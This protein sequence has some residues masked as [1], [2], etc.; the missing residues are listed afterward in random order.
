MGKKRKAKRV[1]VMIDLHIVVAS[2]AVNYGKSLKWVKKETNRDV[3]MNIYSRI[4]YGY[5]ILLIDIKKEV[6]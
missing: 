2:K 4:N 1:K 5:G 3:M 6:N